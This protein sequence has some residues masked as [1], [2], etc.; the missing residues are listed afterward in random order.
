MKLRKELVIYRKE[1]FTT[2]T[3]KVYQELYDDGNFNLKGV[4][5]SLGNKLGIVKIIKSS[6]DINKMKKGEIMVAHGTDFDLISIMQMAGGIII[7]EGGI[8]SHASVISREFGI[9]C[10]IGVNNATKLLK[11]NMI[12]ELDFIRE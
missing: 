6:K 7:K 9:P 2:D 5:A 10:I 1:F 4:C 3:K 8:L 11:D 12:G